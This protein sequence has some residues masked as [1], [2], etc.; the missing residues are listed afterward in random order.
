MAHLYLEWARP[1][2]ALAVLGP[3]LAEHERQ[4]T[5]GFILWE[6]GVMVPLLRL[7]VERGVHAA[8]AAHVL[9]LFRATEEAGPTHVP[10]TGQVLTSREVEILRLVAE[11][12]TDGQVAERLY[13]SPRTVSQHLRSI[14]RKLDVPSRTAAARRAIER[15]LI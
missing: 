1:E 6:G 7:A 14:Y 3:A 9:D 13:I 2:E 4:G 8:F 10:E 11:G 12:L 15:E 5:P